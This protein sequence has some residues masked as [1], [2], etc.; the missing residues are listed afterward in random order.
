MGERTN[1]RLL[2]V[3]RLVP[4]VLVWVA[5]WVAMLGLDHQVDLAN[6]AML[7]VLA[8]A[9]AT[10]WLPIGA[11][12]LFTALS[13]LAFNW[14]FVP[15]RHAFSVD[16]RQDALL[17][18]AMLAVSW[19]VA[20]VVAR[21]R[22]LAESARRQAQRAEQLRSLGEAL[23][24]ADDAAQSAQVLQAVLAELLGL[25]PK[26]LVLRD[27]MPADDDPAAA[28]LIGEPTAHELTGMWHCMRQARAFG[29]GT[30]HHADLQEWYLPLRARHAAFGAVFIALGSNPPDDTMRAQAQ[31]LRD[32]LGQFLQ[33]AQ[34][35]R[36]AHAA[37]EQAQAQ[38]MRNALLAA[39]SHDYRTPLAAIMGAASSLNEQAD[40][41]APGKRQR[42]AHSIVDQ[43]V[44]LSRLTDHGFWRVTLH[45]GFM[46]TADVPKALALCESRGLQIPP[47]ETT[48]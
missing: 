24:D 17:L 20:G 36:A 27:A 28:L 18:G 9:I 29:P 6:L 42:L 37:R 33:R 10:L 48:Y 47:F 2:P 38:G 41:L 12:L 11:S 19:I 43:A 31:A 23:R 22:V 16:L 4:A 35:Q 34:T 14:L 21:Q 7:L 26:M 8:S 15:P 46:Q 5:A 45:F 30:G 13:V 39:I 32:Q 3:A 25:A 1:L 40:R 44:Q